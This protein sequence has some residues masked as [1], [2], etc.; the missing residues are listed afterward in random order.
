MGTQIKEEEDPKEDLSVTCSEY[1]RLLLIFSNGLYKVIPVTEKLYVGQDLEWFG[2][3]EKNTIFNMIYRD[4]AENFAYVKRFETPSFILEK[5]YRLFPEHKRS[6]ILLLT[7]GENNFAKINLMPSSRARINSLEIA[8][9]DYLIKNASAKGKRVSNRVVRRVSR[10]TGVSIEPVKQNLPFPASISLV[11]LCRTGTK[12]VTRKKRGVTSEIWFSCGYFCPFPDMVK[13]VFTPINSAC[14]NKDE[15]ICSP[16][17]LA[18]LLL[19]VKE[20][21]PARVINSNV[22]PQLL[23]PSMS[24]TVKTGCPSVNC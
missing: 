3:V 1:D 19:T 17:L 18:R 2:I 7:F 13:S 5:E 23:K 16:L 9:D 24:L 6:R 15:L 14:V 12:E 20:S 22:P 4:G 10:S 21:L 11:P 8:F